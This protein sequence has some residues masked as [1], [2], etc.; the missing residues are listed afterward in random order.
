V[1]ESV[2]EKKVQKRWRLSFII[3]ERGKDVEDPVVTVA[4]IGFLRQAERLSDVSESYEET[5]KP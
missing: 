3:R 1:R 5:P 4:S 2:K